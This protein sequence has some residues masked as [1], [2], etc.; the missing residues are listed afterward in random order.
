MINA[1]QIC[2][3]PDYVLVHEDVKEAFITKLKKAITAMYG[4]D[5]KQSPDYARM[6]SDKRFRTVSSYL[7]NPHQIIFGGEMDAKERYIAPT[8]LDN[9]DADDNVMREEIFG[10]VLPIISYRDQREVFESISRNP[11]PLA[12][13]VYT[14]NK[15]TAKFYIENVRF[16]GGCVNNGLIHLGNP[17]L[18]FGGVGTSGIGESH[19]RHGY[20]TF[21]R[22]KS[23]MHTPTWFDTPLWYPPYKDNVKWIRKIFR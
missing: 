6:I 12:L 10:P 1:G 8:L 23:M 16:G 22:E 18:P 3:A 5:P 7:S 17:E 11:Y 4:T 19:G 21:T 15:A 2:V 14:N 9:V 20:E 13:Y